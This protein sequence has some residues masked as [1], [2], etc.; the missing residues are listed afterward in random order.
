MTGTKLMSVPE[1]ATALGL[2]QAA[3]RRWLLERRIESIKIG[4]LIRI[5]VSEVERI[6]TEGFRPRKGAR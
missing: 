1:F 6:L 3:V 2:T 5:P 4:R